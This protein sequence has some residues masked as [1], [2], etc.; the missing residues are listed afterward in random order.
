MLQQAASPL[1]KLQWWSQRHPRVQQDAFGL[2]SSPG[3][4]DTVVQEHASHVSLVR[5]EKSSATSR[6][7]SLWEECAEFRKKLHTR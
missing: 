6:P 7:L 4:S 1:V 2:S 3:P 5:T